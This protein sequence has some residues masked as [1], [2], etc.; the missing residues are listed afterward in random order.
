[1][2]NLQRGIQQLAHRLESGRGIHQRGKRRRDAAHQ[3]G[4][5]QNRVPQRRLLRAV[6]RPGALNNIAD[7]HIR[8]AG[9]FAAFAV[10]AVFQR[11]IV[12]LAVLQAQALA[13]RP[14][15]F[16]PGI[17]WV[18]AADRADGGTHRAF[19]AAFKTGVVHCSA[20]VRWLIC[21]ATYSAVTAQTPPPHPWAMGSYPPSSE[22]MAKRVLTGLPES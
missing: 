19:D 12:Q 3:I 20:S 10:D 17:A 7:F 8:R 15:L 13:V 1:M 21:S 11:F 9:D 2:V 22:P 14:G 6:A 16:R 18:H 5:A 4:V